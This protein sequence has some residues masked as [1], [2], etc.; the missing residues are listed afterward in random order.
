MIE[1]SLAGEVVSEKCSRYFKWKSDQDS[2]SAR[3][4]DEATVQ[5]LL[6]SLLLPSAPLD[7]LAFVTSHLGSRL[8]PAPT[9]N[10]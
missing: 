5:S 9:L 8:A 1:G 6:P 4:L 10:C 3:S 7:P 2:K